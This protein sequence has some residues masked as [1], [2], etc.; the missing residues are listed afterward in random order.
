MFYRSQCPEL[1]TGGFT[2]GTK[3]M[4]SDYSGNPGKYLET[5]SGTRLV[6]CIQYGTV[7]VLLGPFDQDYPSSLSSVSLIHSRFL[8]LDVPDR[9][10]GN[11]KSKID[12]LGDQFT[13]LSD[14]PSPN[15]SGL[16]CH[17]L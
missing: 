3:T 4:N 7:G 13:P 5:R 10:L 17:F 8:S 9:H 2:N 14:S 6:E 11:E 1:A 16:L 15:P 12:I